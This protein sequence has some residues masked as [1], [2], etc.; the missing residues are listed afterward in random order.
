VNFKTSGASR[1]E[2]ANACRLSVHVS[3]RHCEER[4]RRSNPESFRGSWIAWLALAMTVMGMRASLQIAIP[5]FEAE[6]LKSN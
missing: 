5:C 6:N 4:L 1:R 2:T 3:H